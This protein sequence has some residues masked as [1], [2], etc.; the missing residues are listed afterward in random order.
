MLAW[1]IA[2]F[3]TAFASLTGSLESTGV[4]LDLAPTYEYYR[5]DTKLNLVPYYYY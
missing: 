2:K 4:N 5:Y 3:S 1:K